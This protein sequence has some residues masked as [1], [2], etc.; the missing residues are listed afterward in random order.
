M[1]TKHFQNLPLWGCLFGVFVIPVLVFLLV[2]TVGND[3]GG[4]LF[5]PLLSIICG[6]V[7]FSIGKFIQSRRK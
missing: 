3:L 7:G 6:I 5:W 1:K 4:P 2:I